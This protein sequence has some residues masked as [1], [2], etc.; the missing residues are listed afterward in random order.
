MS[1]KSGNLGAYTDCKAVME[2]ARETPGL[3]VRFKTPGSAQNF[4][5]RCYRFRKLL[6]EMQAS[7][8]IGF[9]ATETPYDNLV[10]RM[11]EPT[12]VRFDHTTLEAEEITDADGNPIT[13]EI[14][15]GSIFDD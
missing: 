15:K 11:P 9:L 8:T 10:L 14:P 2:K 13:V 12:A 1:A 5:Q 3:T 7:S 4:R 6:H